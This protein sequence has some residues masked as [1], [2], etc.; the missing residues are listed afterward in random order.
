MGRNLQTSVKWTFLNGL[1]GIKAGLKL[2]AQWAEKQGKE[3]DFCDFNN[4][5]ELVPS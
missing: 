1:N 4:F 5:V 2:A 3:E